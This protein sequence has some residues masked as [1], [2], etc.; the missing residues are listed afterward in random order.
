MNRLLFCLA[1]LLSILGSRAT[2]AEPPSA[3]FLPLMFSAD[4][5]RTIAA[6]L[7]IHTSPADNFIQEKTGGEQ[8]VGYAPHFHLS[9]IVFADE[10]RWTIWINDR[11][12]RK[13][14]PSSRFHVED[15]RADSVVLSFP[16]T[17]DEEKRI[18][19]HPNQTYLLDDDRLMEGRP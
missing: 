11:P 16:G 15:V 9:A 13:D 5:H 12:V 7:N 8:K 4:T 18:R 17:G 6:A 1:C 10:D 14:R 3:S 19:L 2:Q